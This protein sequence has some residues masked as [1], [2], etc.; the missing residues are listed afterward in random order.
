MPWQT[1]KK[2]R[3]CEQ[4]ENWLSALTLVKSVLV[5]RVVSWEPDRDAGLGFQHEGTASHVG[6]TSSF[7]DW[8]IGA[9]KAIPI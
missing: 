7:W 1:Q 8:Y 6:C 2:R 9:N 4:P 5:L 3:Q